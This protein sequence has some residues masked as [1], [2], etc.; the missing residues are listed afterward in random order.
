MNK[1][2]KKIKKYLYF[3]LFFIPGL[4]T[5][6]FNADN[7]QPD[8]GMVE[9]LPDFD[10][11]VCSVNSSGKCNGCMIEHL[12]RGFETQSF[13]WSKIQLGRGLFDLFI[14]DGFKI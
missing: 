11:S 2:R 8:E 12:E 6:C 14:R 3:P 7:K 9:P 5:S 4:I 1:P 13:A 10:P